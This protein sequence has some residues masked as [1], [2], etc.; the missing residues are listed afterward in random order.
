MIKILSTILLFTVPIF[1]QNF[2]QFLEDAIKN[3]PYLKSSDLSIEQ[4]KQR[5]QTLTRYKNPSLEMEYSQFS[6]KLSE[7][8]N[9]Y[10]LSYSQPLR[11]WGV[12]KDKSELSDAML[13]STRSK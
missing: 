12:G 11:L 5:A 1:G 7:D 9:G 3:S 10:R 4:S 2:N 6:S 8:E 13:K